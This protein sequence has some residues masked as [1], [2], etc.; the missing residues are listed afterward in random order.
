MYGVMDL[1]DQVCGGSGSAVF[2]SSFVVL[3]HGQWKAFQE[4]LTQKPVTETTVQWFLQKAIFQRDIA[5]HRSA[6][7][8]A[9]PL[10]HAKQGLVKIPF[11]IIHGTRDVIV[12]PAEAK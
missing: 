1:A 10:Y 11:L 8:E 12:P 3:Q 2:L 9:S 5:T 6:F 4:R 7:L